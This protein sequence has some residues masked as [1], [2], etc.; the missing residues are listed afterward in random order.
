MLATY[1]AGTM[2]FSVWQVAG[3][4]SWIEDLF[5]SP[6]A[7]LLVSFS[8]VGLYFSLRVW[9]GFEAGEP[10]RRAWQ[11]IT[12]SAAA[13]FAASLLV[14]IFG[15][16]LRLNPLSYSGDGSSLPTLWR[17]AGLMLGGTCRFAMLAVGLL[18]VILIYRRAGFLGRL[19]AIDWAVLAISGVF[20]FR[21]ALEV[22]LRAR[23]GKPFTATEIFNL[24]VDPLLWVLLWQSLLLFR[25]VRQMGLGW[26]GKCYGAFS[27]GIVLVL[28]GDLT[29]WATNWGYLPWPWSSLGWYVWIPAAGAFAVA[30]ALQWEAMRSAE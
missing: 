15:T 12:L 21:E 20:I 27:V 30:P 22:V 1:L 19:A 4:D 14:Q 25:S 10:M 24:P 6:G 9:R 13:D 5:R 23:N 3:S 17:S 26:I 8:G 18:L 16:Q 11:L 29:I 28:L 7:L 2:V